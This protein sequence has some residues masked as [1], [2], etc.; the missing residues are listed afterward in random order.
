MIPQ[1]LRQQNDPDDDD[2]PATRQRMS[3]YFNHRRET[4]RETMQ[5]SS[6]SKCVE[7]MASAL[8]NGEKV[9]L[10]GGPSGSYGERL[11]RDPRFE[12]LVS[13][14]KGR[15]DASYI[16]PRGI[17]CVLISNLVS[18]KLTKAV[19]HQCEHKK[20]PVYGTF[21]SAGCV[22]RA[23]ELAAAMA[24]KPEKDKPKLTN[25]TGAYVNGHV[26]GNVQPPP[27][28]SVSL[29]DADEREAAR[30]LAD[31]DRNVRQALAPPTIQAAGRA[32]A[33]AD[34]VPDFDMQMDAMR[35]VFADARAA[36]D[37]AEETFSAAMATAKDGIE[38]KAR[39]TQLE[40]I[41]RGGK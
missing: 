35:R 16:L 9:L 25:G 6:D 40:A 34:A 18:V 38:A 2:S 37:L 33:A 14:E 3:N 26:N 24:P 27:V 22:Q 11:Q 15:H 30:K 36:I 20:V 7:V 28:A 21:R 39:L 23:A 31:V 29:D 32:L 1:Q 41:F 8:R 19:V 10:V 5:P 13:T 12:Q 4:V 17:G